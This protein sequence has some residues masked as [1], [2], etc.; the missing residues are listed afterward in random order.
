MSEFQQQTCVQRLDLEDTHLGYAESRREQGRLE[1]E[2]AMKE[3]ALRDT[4]IRCIHDTGELKR[5]QELRVNGFSVQKLRR[6]WYDTETHFTDTRVA[7]KGELH[8][9]NTKKQ[10]RHTV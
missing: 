7:T 6:L 9:E 1:E 2:L 10:N 3:E 8:E 5:A 4:Q